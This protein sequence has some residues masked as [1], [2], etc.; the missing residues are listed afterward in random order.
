MLKRAVRAGVDR[1]V[2]KV[3]NLSEEVGEV[4]VIANRAGGLLSVCASSSARV[5]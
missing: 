4:L 1:R 5:G 2:E 3:N